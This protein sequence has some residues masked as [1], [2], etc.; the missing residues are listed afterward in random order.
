MVDV[1]FEYENDIG[2]LKV[3]THFKTKHTIICRKNND[4]SFRLGGTAINEVATYEGV[5]LELCE[6]P[7]FKAFV[8]ENMTIEDSGILST[9]KWDESDLH[10]FVTEYYSLDMETTWFISKQPFQNANYIFINL[11]VLDGGGN[12]VKRW[13]VSPFTGQFRIING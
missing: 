4:E 5:I 11:D 9:E 1:S 7:K 3:D 12:L 8:K 13:R 10:C 2:L 6:K